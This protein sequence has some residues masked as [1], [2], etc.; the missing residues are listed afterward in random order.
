MSKVLQAKKMFIVENY[1][2]S[3]QLYKE[4]ANEIGFKFFKFN[5][6][7]CNSKLRVNNNIAY[8]GNINIA[9]V[10]DNAYLIPT[11]VAV[12]SVIKNINCNMQC[13]I[14]I[15][16]NKIHPKD[17]NILKT[18]SKKNITI[19][20]INIDKCY[21]SYK[22]YTKGFHVSPSAIIKF[23]LPN[24]LKNIDKVLYL[25]GDI[26]ANKDISGLFDIDIA[27]CY[28][29]V[30][31][32]I[33]PLLKYKPSILQKLSI[34]KHK[35]YFN[36]GV[37]LLNLKLMREHKISE[38]LFEYRKYGINYFMDQDAL[39]VIFNNNVKYID[40]SFN[41]LVTLFSEF[42]IKDILKYYYNG[43]CISEYKIIASAYVI[44]F[45][46]KNKPWNNF[47]SK[48]ARLWNE[49][50]LLS[51]KKS[52]D[53][54]S[55]YFFDFDSVNATIVS[56]T[57]FPARINTVHNTIKS[58]LNQ[59]YK[60]AK[61]VLWLAES[62]FPHREAELPIDLIVLKKNGLEIGWCEDLLSYKKLIPTL[63]KY[64]D[65]LI[66][67][68]DDD[69]N[70]NSKWLLQLL[71]SY[72]C[73]TKAI[74]CHRAHEI[75]FE[76]NKDVLPYNKWLRNS[77]NNDVSFCN[78]FTGV[79]GVLYPKKSLASDVLLS[80]QFTQVCPTGD[81]IWFWGMAVLNG[82]KIK[83]VEN[84]SFTLDLLDNT[85]EVALWK[86]NDRGG[87]NDFM[88]QKLFT[89][90]PEIKNQIMYDKQIK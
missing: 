57:S 12:Y 32:D 15:I 59:E 45:A 44:H 85:Q 84:S 3:L 83:I 1:K 41:L 50:Y 67:T 89:Y 82:T 71:T 46:S 22:I 42:S 79:G 38:K 90:Y 72:M 9:F 35:G 63:K 8:A 6:E 86:K 24:I 78:F 34:N 11:Y 33:K 70:Y 18:L 39:N 2:K 52:I 27:G 60:A 14:Y 53:R 58:L 4:L 69:V 49:Y 20:I 65:R 54:I 81:D 68:A 19:Q 56:L 5:I 37:L 13:V 64:S 76:K 75:L 55:T 73:D 47:T 40:L 31:N 51:H 61:I 26:I 66:V 62:Q 10:C 74:H 87:V 17:S 7:Y 43:K 77:K 80:E 28:A 23:Q 21:D 25:D 36:S 88:L 29:A 16:A 48:M 30:V